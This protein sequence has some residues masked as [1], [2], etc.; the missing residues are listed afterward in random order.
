[1]PFLKKFKQIPSIVHDSL[2]FYSEREKRNKYAVLK[3]S[4]PNSLSKFVVEGILPRQLKILLLIYAFSVTFPCYCHIPTFAG[5]SFASE[6]RLRGGCDKNPHP[7]RSSVPEEKIHSWMSSRTA[8][9]QFS[10]C[11][12][13]RIGETRK[14]TPHNGSNPVNYLLTVC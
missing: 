14:A 13:Q 1:M 12:S 10:V 3:F 7:R 6:L 2:P 8:Q 4:L 9:L 11:G 5:R